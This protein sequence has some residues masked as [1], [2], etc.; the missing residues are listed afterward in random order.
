MEDS[1]PSLNYSPTPLHQLAFILQQLADELLVAKVG[2][3][4]SQARIMSALQKSSVKSQ[5]LIAA[6]LGQTE[7]NVSRQLR[8]MKREDLVS[9]TKNK[10][11]ARQRDVSL[12]TKGAHKKD[13]ADELLVE[14]Q[15]ELLKLLVGNSE[16][17]EFIR[18][19]ER[20][21]VALSARTARN[22]KA[23]GH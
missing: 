9:I 16:V 12:T 22:Q 11:D 18:V 14:Q 19:C 3:G 1:E 10:K 8:L 15:T 6:Q 23:L 20:L 5:R 7:A 13:K 4:L 17:K 2:V 21:L